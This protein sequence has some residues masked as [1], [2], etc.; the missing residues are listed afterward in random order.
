MLDL[1][2]AG[3]VRA[4]G[5][6][7]AALAARGAGFAAVLALGA[8]GWTPRGLQSLGRQQVGLRGR[9]VPMGCC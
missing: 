1:S 8:A 5:L 7:A 4:F 9:W 6:D 3:V 2:L